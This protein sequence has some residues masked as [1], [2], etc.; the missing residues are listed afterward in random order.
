MNLLLSVKSFFIDLSSIIPKMVYYICVSFMSLMDMFQFV[1]RKLAGLDSYYI[2]DGTQAQS[3]DIATNFI[4]S[5]FSNN[6]SFPAL[7]TAFWSLLILGVIMLIV[8]TIIAVIRQE[9]MPGSQEMKEKPTNNKYY[10][11]AA[12]VKSF[13]LF[14]IVPVSAVFGLMFA[15]ITLQALDRVTSAESSSLFATANV[16]TKLRGEEF[17]GNTTYVY[18]DIFTASYPTTGTSFSGMMFKTAAFSANRVRINENIDGQSFYWQ[19]SHDNIESFDIFNQAENQYDMAEMIDTAF[20]NHIQLN[21]DSVDVRIELGVNADNAD[22]M[23]FGIK[24]GTEVYGFSKFNVGLV[25]YYYNLWHFNFIIGFAFLVIGAQLLVN[26]VTGLMKRTIELVALFLI[27]PPIIA[28]MPLDEGKIFNKWRENFMSRALGAFGVVIGMNLLFLVLPYIQL[29]HIFPSNSYEVYNFLNLIIS[30]IFVVVGLQ[31]VESFIAL[32]SKIAGADD[33]AA[34]GGKIVAAVGDTIKKSAMLAAGGAGLAFKATELAGKLTAKTAAATA[35]A[36]AKGSSRAFNKFRERNMTE[37]EKKARADAR[38]QKME[39]KALDKEQKEREK[40][41][42]LKP[43]GMMGMFFKNALKNIED[44]GKQKYQ[45]EWE[46]GAGDEAYDQLMQK[47]E[48]YQ[49][50]MDKAYEDYTTKHN[51]KLSKELWQKDKKQSVAAKQKAEANF[52]KRKNL[53]RESYKKDATYRDDYV[54]KNIIDMKNNFLTSKKQAI[55]RVGGEAYNAFVKNTGLKNLSTSG[56]LLL[57]EIKNTF[58]RGGKGGFP[59]LHQMF[60]AKS[61]AQD[62]E[63]FGLKKK[64]QKEESQ[65]VR[66]QQ[67]KREERENKEN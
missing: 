7:K 13:F 67:E 28:I 60:L 50:E 52:A 45:D 25:A 31:M 19:L 4:Q 8:T 27:S 21:P 26:I 62:I 58:V 17:N 33:P 2:G 54:N 46:R 18:F 41:A 5:I 47:D 57:E 23:L 51:G 6:S 1:L 34:S 65:R 39:Q 11:I 61:K 9:Y 64:Q 36:T 30:T 66:V 22:S 24:D 20:A 40:R 37:D 44:A 35:K 59:A 53:D 15:N 63:L 48:Q 16:V 32:I 29:I 56:E 42:Q 55:Q 14:L 43:K 49:Q 3:G 10:V 38:R 12:S